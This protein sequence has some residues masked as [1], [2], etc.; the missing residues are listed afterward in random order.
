MKS[1]EMLLSVGA[2]TGLYPV[3]HRG[4]QCRDPDL[5]PTGWHV[6]GEMWTFA[7]ETCACVAEPYRFPFVR[8]GQEDLLT[9]IEY[10]VIG[11]T[12]GRDT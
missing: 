4:A 5:A 2:S 8:R 11:D 9:N 7:R 10:S 1:L 6:Q 12:A 3:G